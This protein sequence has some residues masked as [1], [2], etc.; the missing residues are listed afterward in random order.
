MSRPATRS[1]RRAAALVAV[2]ATSALL[3]ACSDDTSSSSTTTTAGSTSGASKITISTKVSSEWKNLATCTIGPETA[4]PGGTPAKEGIDGVIDFGKQ[5]QTHVESCVDYP[6]RPAIGGAHYPVWSNC[7][8]YTS[9]VPEEVAVHDLEH[10][11]VWIA[12]DPALDQTEL[13]TIRAAAKSSTHVIASPY[14]G[15]T[16][17]VVMSAWSRQLRLSSADDPRFQK[18]LDV[19]VQGDQTPELGAACSGGVGTPG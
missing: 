15:L 13:A 4:D 11:A 17:K 16:D 10:G 1:A 3:G 14:P 2:L 19:Y 12:F 9:P 8:F 6:V 5:A 7:G 18:F